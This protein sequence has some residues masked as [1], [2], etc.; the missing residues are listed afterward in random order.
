MSEISGDNNVY[1]TL[2]ETYVIL[3]R[4]NT[5][6]IDPSRRRQGT[7][8][9]LQVSGRQVSMPKYRS[10]ARAEAIEIVSAVLNAIS[11]VVAV[12][13]AAGLPISPFSYEWRALFARFA[14]LLLSVNYLSPG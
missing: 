13:I 2:A 12:G 6:V 7:V 8:D 14:R 10:T 4:D 11:V 5:Y 1:L 3:Y 9:T